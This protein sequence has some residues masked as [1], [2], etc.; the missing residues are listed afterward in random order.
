LF[1][2]LLASAKKR[3]QQQMARKERWRKLPYCSLIGKLPY[4]WLCPEPKAR[5]L[6]RCSYN[7]T[8]LCLLTCSPSPT[9]LHLLELIYL[10][11]T[12]SLVITTLLGYYYP[13]DKAATCVVSR[14][15]THIWRQT[16][17]QEGCTAG[18]WDGC[19]TW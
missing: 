14:Q 16:C 5:E 7:T 13:W 12:P 2:Y 10:P 4:C 19:R 1:L 17:F 15:P 8:C 6:N 11:I 3:H 18:I 9:N